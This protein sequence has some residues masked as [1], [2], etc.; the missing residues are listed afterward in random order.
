MEVERE[1]GERGEGGTLAPGETH[2]SWPAFNIQDPDFGV[3]GAEGKGARS[4]SKSAAAGRGKEG[5]E[6]CQKARGKRKELR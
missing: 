6:K 1:T 5:K 4:A 2:N 3:V